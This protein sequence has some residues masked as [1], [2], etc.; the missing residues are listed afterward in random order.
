MSKPECLTAGIDV[1]KDDLDIAILPTGTLHRVT[2][3]ETGHA[4]LVALL[5][6]AG[7]RV[8]IARVVMEATGGYERDP[9]LALA[10]A[11]LPVVVV[12]CQRRLGR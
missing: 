11:S 10:D 8:G 7:E 12:N 9:A 5:Q 2:N 1:G 6:T 3:D 4:E